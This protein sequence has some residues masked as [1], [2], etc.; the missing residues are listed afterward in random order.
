MSL[1]QF[2]PRNAV[3]LVFIVLV[4]LLRIF[5]T[6]EAPMS[7]LST[8]TPLGAMALFGG[9]YFNNRIKSVLFPVLTLWVSDIILNRFVYYNEWRFFYE[10][11]Y[12]TYGSYA[13]MAIASKYIIRRAT[14]GNIIIASVAATLIH[15]IGTSPGCF[16]IENSMYPKTWAGY[17]TSLVAAIP[18]ERNFLVGTLAYGGL[19]F[20]TFEWLQRRYHSLKLAH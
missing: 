12:W 15:W 1:K 9:A 14:V 7:A 4:A 10:G 16:M 20:T 19:M 11:F 2:N 6:S 17:F 3:L 5:L 13:L 18:Y 8:F